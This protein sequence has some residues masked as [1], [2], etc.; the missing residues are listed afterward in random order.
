MK[1]SFDGL[2]VTSFESRRAGEIEKLI[3]YHGGNPRVAPSMKELPNAESPNAMEFAE[4]LFSNEIDLLILMTGVGTRYLSEIVTKTY[5]KDD[6]VKALSG[7][8]LLARG[9]KPVSAL[10]ELNLKADITVPEPNTWR[11]VLTTIDEVY[12][13][14]GKSVYVQEYGISNQK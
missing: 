9:P 1:Y 3:S 10:R 5:D 8:T 14:E 7:I 6:Y 2:N 11:D 4:K 13:I 12:E